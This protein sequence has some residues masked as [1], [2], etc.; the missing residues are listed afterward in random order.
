MRV[1]SAESIESIGPIHLFFTYLNDPY[2][3]IVYI[4]H[5]FIISEANHPKSLSIQPLGSFL[6]ILFL[7]SMG[8]SIDFND[9]FC[10]RAIKIYNKT[11]KWHLAAEF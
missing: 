8:T 6:V 10:R 2:R 9:E 11:T 5:Y 7:F 1:I 4:I 3:H